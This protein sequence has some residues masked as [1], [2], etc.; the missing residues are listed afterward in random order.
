MVSEEALQ[1][2]VKEKLRSR[3]FLGTFDE[4]I[5]VPEVN[6]YRS[7]VVL[8]S[9]ET[10]LSMILSDIGRRL[11]KFYKES[12]YWFGFS[13]GESPSIAITTGSLFVDELDEI[14]FGHFWFQIRTVRFKPGEVKVKLRVLR[15]VG[16]T[17]FNNS[18]RSVSNLSCNSSRSSTNLTND[19]RES[20]EWKEIFSTWAESTSVNVKEFLYYKVN[21]ENLKN[22]FHLL[23][24]LTIGFVVGAVEFIKYVGNF[25]IRFMTEFS[26]LLHV[27]TPI[28]FGV[29]DL[30]SRIIGGFFIFLTMLWK[31]SIGGKRP[32]AMQAI[33][34]RPPNQG[35]YR[36]FKPKLQ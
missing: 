8:S 13:T 3:I 11:K 1:L 36:G 22:V 34:Y 15:Q 10:E 2:E 7:V 16:E 18:K 4:K 9:S 19:A 20:I 27:C 30:F 33:Q 25:S 23:S 12:P 24:L 17:D 35:D 14:P 31:D 26:R 28:F 29:L 21:R 6:D 5:F 32:P